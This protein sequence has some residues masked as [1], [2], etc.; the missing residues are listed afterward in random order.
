MDMHEEIAGTVTISIMDFDRMRKKEEQYL[1]IKRE[2]EKQRRIMSR[3]VAALIVGFD[4][5]EFEAAINEI[6]ND[7]SIISDAKLHRMFCDAM[8]K[9]KIIIDPEKLKD[10]LCEY[11]DNSM[12]ENYEDLKNTDRKTRKKIEVIIKKNE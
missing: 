8:A 5:E 6:D 7:K 1:K 4:T 2:M 10:L 3:K 11:I 9:M 12:G